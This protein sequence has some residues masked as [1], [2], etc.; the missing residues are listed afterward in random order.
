M[1]QPSNKQAISQQKQQAI[2][3][4]IRLRS[5]DMDEDELCAFADWL[6]QDHANSEAFA[7]AEILFEKM[8]LA[9][10]PEAEINIVQPIKQNRNKSVLFNWLAPVFTVAAIWLIAVNLFLPQQ[11]YLLDG[12]TS[13]YYT[14]T[15]ELRNVQLSDGSEVL[16]NTNSAISVD[17]NKSKRQ[18]ILHHGLAR[19]SVAKD[20][21]R[22]FEVIVDNLNVRALGTIFQV[23]R[24]AENNIKV[25]VQEHAVAVNLMSSQSDTVTVQTGQQLYIQQKNSLSVPTAVELNQE[26]AWQHRRLVVN[27]QPLS[28]LI[29]ELERYRNGRIFLSDSQ[30]KELRVTGVFSLND[31]ETVLTSICEALN[32]KETRVGPLW[33][34]LHR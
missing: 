19:F 34:I 15:G 6:A 26:T 28:D 23:Y 5:D 8:A 14:Q 13:D 16:L 25:T 27:D 11:M 30:L 2:D 9:V 22:P 3:W 21:R 20:R 29:K 12:L 33:S 7:E 10:A 4:L 32:L 1:S 17:Y 31:P 24:S 18:I